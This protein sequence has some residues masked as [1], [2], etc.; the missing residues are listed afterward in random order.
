[1]VKVVWGTVYVPIVSVGS[2]E[3]LLYLHTVVGTLEKVN[4]VSPPAENAEVP[5]TVVTVV[6][7]KALP[8]VQDQIDSLDLS[9]LSPEEQDQVRCLL[10]KNIPIFST[11]NSE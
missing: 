2:T 9:S 10:R 11:H 1:M 6:S 5:S 3:V 7:Q 8:T 4:V